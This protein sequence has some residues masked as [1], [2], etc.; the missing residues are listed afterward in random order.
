MKTKNKR[1]L[2]KY[3]AEKAEG[4]VKQSSGKK[5]TGQRQGSKQT[6]TAVS[7]KAPNAG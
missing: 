3:W 4:K 1:E 7:R 5:V 2:E 6:S